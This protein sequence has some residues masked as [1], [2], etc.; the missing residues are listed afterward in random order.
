M[1]SEFRIISLRFT[2]FFFKFNEIYYNA[3]AFR[4][5][6]LTLDLVLPRNFNIVALD[7]YS[8]SII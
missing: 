5:V 3:N 7:S 8:S 4:K 1:V 6:K 2:L